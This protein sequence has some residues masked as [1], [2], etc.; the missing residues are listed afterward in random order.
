MKILKQ[1]F[2]AMITLINNVDNIPGTQ[3]TL[4]FVGKGLVLE[5]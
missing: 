4:A 3:I 1:R 2:C 5:G